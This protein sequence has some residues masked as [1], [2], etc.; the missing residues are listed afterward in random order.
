MPLF[1]ATSSLEF[2]FHSWIFLFA[3]MGLFGRKKTS[4]YPCDR[5]PFRNI[6]I[7]IGEIR[8]LYPFWLVELDC[9]I[10]CNEGCI[11]CWAFS[12]YS[13]MWARLSI[14]LLRIPPLSW[15]TLQWILVFVEKDEFINNY[16]NM[17]NFCYLYLFGY[18]D[19]IKFFYIVN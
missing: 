18:I 7:L 2:F 10:H 3:A 9:F 5:L 13:R 15:E 14:V 19:N 6:F 4:G 8:L 1:L 12:F 16:I 17:L 11:F